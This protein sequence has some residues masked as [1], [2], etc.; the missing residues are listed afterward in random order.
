MRLIS[1]SY[2]KGA[3]SCFPRLEPIKDGSHEDKVEEGEGQ[4]LVTSRDALINFDS[5]EEILDFVPLA[6]K[7]SVIPSR[8]LPPYSRWNAGQATLSQHLFP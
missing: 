3:G 5:L 1:P 2:G 7:S 6:I 4:F 8:S